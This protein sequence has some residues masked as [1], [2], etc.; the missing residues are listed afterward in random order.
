MNK[1]TILLVIS[2]LITLMG[3][4]PMTSAAFNS[5]L[6]LCDMDNEIDISDMPCMEITPIILNETSGCNVTIMNINYS[7]YNYTINMTRYDSL[8][9][10]NFSLNIYYTNH[11]KE[12]YTMKLCDN[13]TTNIIIN[14]AETANELWVIYLILFIIFFVIFFIGE[15]KKNFIFK[16]LAGAFLLIIGLYLFVNGIPGQQL[17]FLSSGTSASWVSWFS[18]VLILLGLIYNIRTAYENVWESDD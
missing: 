17:S 5:S 13:S 6:P 15:W 4:M 3:I 12:Y 11:S 9:R 10:Y 16:Y 8:G 18:L 1:Q 14:F 2:V 7:Y